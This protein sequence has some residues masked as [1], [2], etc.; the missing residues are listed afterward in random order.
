MFAH[1]DL[2]AAQAAAG[3]F[4]H[5]KGLGQDFIQPPRQFVLVLDLDRRAFQSA[6]FGAARRRKQIFAAADCLHGRFSLRFNR[7][8]LKKSIR[9]ARFQHLP[10]RDGA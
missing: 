9:L 6:V 7:L 5:G 2:L 8:R 4:H 3:V 1:D 10:C